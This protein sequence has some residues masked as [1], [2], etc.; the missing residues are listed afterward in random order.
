M[1]RAALLAVLLAA[2]SVAHANVWQDAVRGGPEPAQE[3]YERHMRE[4]DEHVLLADSRSL[5]RSEV[6]RQVGL[7][8]QSYRAA[9]AAK[10]KEAEPYFRIAT[11]LNSFYLDD[12][13]FDRLPPL[14]D[15]HSNQI[16]LKIAQATVDAWTEF[17]KRAP[18]DPRLGNLLATS[19]YFE[20]A[21]LNTKLG[22]PKHFAAAVK[23]YETLVR[24]SDPQ[25]QSETVW[26]NLAETYMMLGR[27]DDAVDAYR[28]ITSPADISTLYGAAVTLDRA[29]RG[30]K[31]LELLRDRGPEAFAQFQQNVRTGQT[32]FVPAGE[33]FYYFGLGAEALGQYSDALEYFELF[34][35][36]GAHPQFHARAKEHIAELAKKRGKAPPLPEPT[37]EF[38]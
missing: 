26:S 13:R 35:Q 3:Q 29:G 24:R 17:E 4:G 21:I 12:C 36:S 18:L 33:Q 28:H 8:L 9:A 1:M 20:R 34:V 10:P 19:I 7:A 6:V 27:L 14:R 30:G 5:A 2:T 16:D 38:R 32:F 37:R 25:E 23:D 31:A 22:T 11:V 15:C